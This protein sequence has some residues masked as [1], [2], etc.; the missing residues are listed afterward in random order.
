MSSFLRPSPR[1]SQLYFAERVKILLL[2]GLHQ[3]GS[4]VWLAWQLATGAT[5]LHFQAKVHRYPPVFMPAMMILLPSHWQIQAP[6]LAKSQESCHCVCEEPGPCTATGAGSRGAEWPKTSKHLQCST[7][8][9]QIN[10][11]ALSAVPIMSR[12]PPPNNDTFPP[13]PSFFVCCDLFLGEQVI[14]QHTHYSKNSRPT[15]SNS[16]SSFPF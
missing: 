13:H 15:L 3:S 12:P 16:R 4:G 9:G 1:H 6:H 10:T 11:A 8:P 14:T 5:G 7:C 2:Q